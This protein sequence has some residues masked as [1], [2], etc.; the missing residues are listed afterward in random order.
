MTSSIQEDY[1]R[2]RQAVL[3]IG[4]EWTGPTADVREETA[5]AIASAA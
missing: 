1:Q 3:D 5:R 4:T 2:V